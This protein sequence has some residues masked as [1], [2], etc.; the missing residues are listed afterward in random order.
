MKQ[1]RTLQ[2]LATEVE[3]Q[4]NAK[5]DF[6]AD[7]R[8]LAITLTPEKAV[9][10]AVADWDL[11]VRDLAHN[12]IA[13]RLEIPRKYYQKMQAEYPELLVNNING[14]F[15][16]SRDRRLVRTLDGSVRAF[17]SDR[18]RPLDNYDLL[19]AVLPTI[20]EAGMTILSSEITDNRL[21]LK[22]V[23]DKVQGE[24]KKGDIIQAGVCIS[25]SEMGCGALAVEG[26]LYRLVCLNGMVA[27]DSVMRKTHTGGRLN[28]DDNGGLYSDD[29]R[30]ATDKAFWM[31]TRDLVKAA[32]SETMLANNLDKMR[33]AAGIPLPAKI[34]QV[35]EVTGK[36]FSFDEQEKDGVLRNLING[37]DLSLYGLAN[38]TTLLAQM[39]DDYDRATELEAAGG[40]ILELSPSTFNN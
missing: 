13:D 32:V 9:R 36:L 35:V 16:R 19:E 27:P 30:K 29:T 11:T 20:S 21:Y 6:L 18:Y 12:Q 40:R 26:F 1:G 34:D 39:V 10:M 8:A 14:W 15:G 23:N 22:A 38:A 17:L 37:G 24:V 28:G 2:N 33:E 3:R 5:K 31:Q 25:N 4:R 7:E